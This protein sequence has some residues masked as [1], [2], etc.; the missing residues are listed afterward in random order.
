VELSLT[1]TGKHP[2]EF[3]VNRDYCSEEGEDELF[4]II[5]SE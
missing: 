4:R 1:S 3:V 5:V 2:F